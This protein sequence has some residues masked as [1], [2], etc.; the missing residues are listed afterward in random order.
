[1]RK[2]LG[3]ATLAAIVAIVPAALSQ[4]PADQQATPDAQAEPQLRVIPPDDQPSKEQMARLFDAMRLRQQMANITKTLPAMIQQQVSQQIK[5][6]TANT[7]GTPL[8]AEQQAAVDQLMKKYMERA[9]SLYPP[10]EMIA[11]LSGIYQRHLSK[12][13]VDGIIAFYS[14]PAGQHM[15]E[16]APV[17]MK[18]YMPLVM[19]RMQERSKALAEEM[20]KD[21]KET[22]PGWVPPSDGPAA[23]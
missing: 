13:D 20:K 14:S 12:E 6:L 18:E 3:L 23:K 8:T 11:D 22:V 1:M 5:S 21:M 4:A 9:L 7:S 17:A 2:F 19:G 16:L 10:D 15:V